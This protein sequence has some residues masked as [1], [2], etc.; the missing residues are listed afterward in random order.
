MTSV[1]DDSGIY[2]FNALAPAPYKI[3]VERQGFQK[4]TLENVQIIPEQ[5]NSLNLEIAVLVARRPRVST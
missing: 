2:I 5:L 3:S 4:K 1:S